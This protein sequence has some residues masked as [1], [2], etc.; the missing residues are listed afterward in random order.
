MIFF[1]PLS[2]SSYSGIFFCIHLFFIKPYFVTDRIFQ[3]LRLCF[4]HIRID[5]TV[6]RMIR[7]AG[8]PWNLQFK[9]ILANFKICSS[10][11]IAFGFNGL[12]KHVVDMCVFWTEIL[13]TFFVKF[14]FFLLYKM[15]HFVKRRLRMKTYIITKF[16]VYPTWDSIINIFIPKMYCLIVL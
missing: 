5:N 2:N 1:L 16:I 8:K 13:F 4:G 10:K 7:V 9:C 12:K 3:P 15:R 11:Q 14:F 6:Y